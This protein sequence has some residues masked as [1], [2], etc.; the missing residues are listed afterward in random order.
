V[1][2]KG[3]TLNVNFGKIGTKGQSKPKDFATPE[4]AK[5]EMEKL[6]KE[7]TGK[8]YVEVGGK[9]VKVA[10]P[11][12][13]MKTS[14]GSMGKELSK[15]E[16][17]AK[18][19]KVLAMFVKGQWQLAHD[20]L[21][22]AQEEDWL[23]Q[24]LLKGSEIE[25]PSSPAPK[26]QF[27]SFEEFVEMSKNGKGKPK[28]SAGVLKP[29]AIMR[30]YFKN[31]KD[32][33][34]NSQ[35]GNVDMVM[36]GVLLA[37]PVK[38]KKLLKLDTNKIKTVRCIPNLNNLEY[39]ARIHEGYPDVKKWNISPADELFSVVSISDSA[40]KLLSQWWDMEVVSFEKL[41][42]LSDKAIAFLCKPC[43]EYLSLPALKSLSGAAA[44]SFVNLLERGAIGIYLN[45]LKNLSEEA[46]EVISKSKHYFSDD[47]GG[48]VIPKKLQK[49]V[50]EFK[51]KQAKKK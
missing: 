35:Y 18:A 5:A 15:A 49:I 16:K 23:F 29:S 40:A 21:E 17:K 25:E 13:V 4:M 1:D 47:S 46:V 45:G 7:K 28:A 43:P 19:E 38:T 31:L 8:G 14:A 10:K 37:T 27:K 26:K 34:G 44:K 22:A 50:E 20:I 9:A 39:F 6:I 51:E 3:K 12:A 11:A 24:E 42:N 33:F 32:E 2:V 36:L 41:E 48:L 30:Q